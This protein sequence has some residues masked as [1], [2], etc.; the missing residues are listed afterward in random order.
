IRTTNRPVTFRGPLAGS[1]GLTKAGV[2]PATL[3]SGTSTYT[4]QTSIVQGELVFVG[5]VTSGMPGPLGAGTSAIVLSPGAAS[6]AI[7]S[8]GGTATLGRSLLVQ[9]SPAGMAGLG[10]HQPGIRLTMNGDISLQNRLTLWGSTVAVNGTISGPSGLTDGGGAVIELNGNNTY[11]GGTEVL[12]GTWRVG[13]D[14]ALGT[15]PLTFRFN[16]AGT[17]TL[18]AL[19]NRTIA[20]PVIL[21]TGFSIG[22]SS[23]LKLTG[24][25]DLGGVRTH[26]IANTADTEYAGL[27]TNGGLNKTGPGRLILSGYNSYN[28][29]TQVSEGELMVYGIK[30]L[31][32]PVSGTVVNL[33]A[34]LHL[35]Q[36]T[37]IDDGGVV[38]PNPARTV[39]PVTINGE[40]WGGL[41]AL[42]SSGIS[43]AVSTLTLASS[44]TVRVEPASTLAVLA[45]EPFV[46]R[47]L[48]LDGGGTMVSD[49]VRGDELILSAGSVMRLRAG[50]DLTNNSRV[51][52]LSIGSGALDVSDKTL[53]YDYTGPSPLASV[54]ALVSSGYAGGAWNGPGIR[55]S[56]AA[57]VPNRAVGYADASEIGFP[58]TFAG[59]AIDSTT[60][61][62]R[63]TLPGDANLDRWVT[64]TDFSLM[65]SNF[66]LPGTWAKGDFDYSGSVG[67]ADFALLASN[68]NQSM[69][70]GLPR[71]AIPEP[72][73]VAGVGLLWW[74][75]G[76]RGRPSRSARGS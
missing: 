11:T 10:V 65:A 32:D 3:S 63:L 53:I 28:D 49:R 66:N 50:G 16:N 68:F 2:G 58:P 6:T 22:G 42:R 5:N 72:A 45:L 62:V 47:S 34:T 7:L 24:T 56:V 31:G 39:E 36:N 76:A 13:H 12:T 19:G 61:L 57:M 33:G 70:L 67:L 54:A 30:P 71:A 73:G 60:L 59:E 46:G 1:Q 27:L 26:H 51:E 48:T 14:N 52:S 15:C 4:G 17:G 43:T 18:A 9:G 40:G 37:I 20:N 74:L 21:E 75:A 35:A 8:A 55:S 44:S 64:L 23:P 41:G 25:M 38:A 29:L 69:P